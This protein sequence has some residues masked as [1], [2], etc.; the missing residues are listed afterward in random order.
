MFDVGGGMHYR[1]IVSVLETIFT[2]SSD[3]CSDPNLVL[4]I[5]PMAKKPQS[6][7]IEDD[8][9]TISHTGIQETIRRWKETRSVILKRSKK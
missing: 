5:L 2:L 6:I 3:F 8:D 9:I 1:K 4:Q 7:R